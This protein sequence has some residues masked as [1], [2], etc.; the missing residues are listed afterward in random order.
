M[1]KLGLVVILIGIV[2]LVSACKTKIDTQAGIAPVD[3]VKDDNIIIDENQDSGSMMQNPIIELTSE[4][5]TPKSINIK[6]GDKV[7]WVNKIQE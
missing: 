5:Y 4:G 3:E 1:K 6:Q 7:I 2:L